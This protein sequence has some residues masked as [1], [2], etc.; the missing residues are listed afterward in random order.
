MDN[1]KTVE[2]WQKEYRELRTQYDTQLNNLNAMQQ[3]QAT[4]NAE[5]QK[6][7]DELD[8]SNKEVERLSKNVN[9]VKDF[10]RA[11]GEVAGEVKPFLGNR[12]TVHVGGK[13][14]GVSLG[15]KY[16]NSTDD[17]KI[18]DCLRNEMGDAAAAKV[19]ANLSVSSHFIPTAGA[20]KNSIITYG[21]TLVGVGV[22][23][24]AGTRMGEK[25]TT[26]QQ[27]DNVVDINQ[28]SASYSHMSF[29]E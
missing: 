10:G 18:V 13:E 11:L 12:Y 29:G 21:A 8:S 14:Y 6:L 2:D 26:N 22:G 5:K 15:S 19:E 25:A 17:Q 23:V 16:N 4:L 28:P 27:P 20:Y 7:A 3:T 24:F 9:K 1:K